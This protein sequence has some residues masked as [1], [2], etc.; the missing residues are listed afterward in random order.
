MTV[1]LFSRGKFLTEIIRADLQ[2]LPL[3]STSV[4]GSGLAQLDRMTHVSHPGVH[5]P[6]SEQGV[7]ASLNQVASIEDLLINLIVQQT[8]FPK[9]NITLQI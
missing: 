7:P 3:L 9:Q 5:K 1:P 8:G 6:A 4:N 2:T